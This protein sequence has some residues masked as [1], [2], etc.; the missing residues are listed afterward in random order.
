[1]TDIYVNA[2]QMLFSYGAL[3]VVAVY[4]MI[5]DFKVT[6]RTNEAI[7]EFTVALGKLQILV[8]RRLS[9]G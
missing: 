6:K 1:M 9:D 5:K 8:D 4:F 7:K 2:M 3:G